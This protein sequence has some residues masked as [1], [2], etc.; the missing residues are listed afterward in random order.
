MSANLTPEEVKALAHDLDPKLSEEDVAFQVA[1]ILLAVG[2][3]YLPTL[4][5]LAP[6]VSLSRPRIREIIA[7]IREQGILVREDGEWKMACNWM[8]AENGNVAFWM[9]VNVALGLVN[10]VAA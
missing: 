8:D 4:R 10:R 5:Q 6:L 9:D 2:T 3:G 1:V 7:R